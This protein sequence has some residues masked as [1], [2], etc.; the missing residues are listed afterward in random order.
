MQTKMKKILLLLT[1]ALL[2]FGILFFVAVNKFLYADR[3]GCSKCEA[4]M[5]RMEI[6]RDFLSAYKKEKNRY[7]STV[8][9][10]QAMD[11][12]DK[13]RDLFLKDPWGTYYVY[14]SPF[15]ENNRE[16]S[17]LLY[18]IGPNGVDEKG[19]GDDIVCCKDRPR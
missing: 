11:Y 8:E 13:P 5:I 12:P 10:L 18:S 2:I 7:P 6:I 15:P 19:K 17:F 1:V 3:Y 14:I 4:A 9:G 16:D